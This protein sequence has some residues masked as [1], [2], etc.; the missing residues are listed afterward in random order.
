LLK[1]N[2]L[3]EIMTK[4]IDNILVYNLSSEEHEAL[5][6][7]GIIN[8]C[9][10]EWSFSFDT[11]MESNIEILSCFDSE[12]KTELLCDLRQICF[13]H[14]IDFRFQKGFMKSN[15]VMAWK[16]KQLLYWIPPIKRIAICLILFILLTRYWR[17]FYNA[18]NQ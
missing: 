4:T 10:G 1:N 11:F 8:W 6:A 17:K 14:D 12:K 7:C 5:L 13:E 3:K 15:F 18:W 9:W 2:S 16:V